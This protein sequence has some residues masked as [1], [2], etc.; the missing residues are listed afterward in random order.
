MT[1][2]TTSQP[3]AQAAPNERLREQIRLLGNLLGETIIA[4]E[5]RELFDIE[6]TMRALTK[7]HRAGNEDAGRQALEL[8]ERLAQNPRQAAAII[9]A[10]ATYFQLVNLAEEEQRVRVLRR[11][12]RAAARDGYP[13]RESIAAAIFRLREEGFTAEDVQAL[14]RDALVMPVFTAHPT[15]AQRRAMLTKLQALANILYEMDTRDLLPDEEAHLIQ[16]IREIIVALWQTNETRPRPPTV[17]DEV[18]NGLYYFE[19][20]LFDLIPRIYEDLQAA[21]ADMYPDAAFD[22][23]AFLRFGSWMGGDRDGNPYVTTDV[24]EETLRAQKALALKLYRREVAELYNELTMSQKRIGVSQALLDS[25][26]EDAARF[27]DEAPEILDRFADEPYRQK[28]V[29]MHRRIMAAQR[30]TEHAWTEGYHEPGAYHHP[31]EFLA[32]LRLIDES[33]R[34]HKGEILANGRLARLIR[35]VQVFGFHLATLDIRQ[36]SGRHEETLAEIFK[37][38]ALADDYA[39]LDENTKVALLEREINSPRPL[40]AQLTFSPDTNETVRVFRLIRRAHDLL[41]PRAIQSYIISMTTSVSD[42]LEVLL[43]AKDAN[44]FGQIDIVPLFETIEDLHNAP[45]IM[46]ALFEN[47]VYRQ[48]LAARGSRQQIMIGY[49][50]SNK[51][52]GYLTANWELFKAQRALAQT[53]DRYNIQLTLFHG[54][55]GTIGRGGGNAVRAILAQPPESVR[56]RFRVTEQG[57]VISHR[58]GNPHLAHRHLHQIMYAVLLSSGRRPH[59]ERENVWSNAL[60]EMAAI[61]F[62]TYRALVER[63]EF[64]RY[65]HE[66]TPIDHITRLNIG[67]RPAKRRQTQGISDLRAIPWVF[68][69][70][71][72]RVNLPGWY[73]LGTA[74]ETWV[75]QGDEEERIALLSEMYRQW[76]FFRTVID[77]AQMSL[78]KADMTIAAIYATLTDDATRTAV[79][80]PIREEHARTERMI[81]RITGYSDLLENEPWLQQSIRLRNPYVDPMNYIQVA[82]IRRLRETPPPENSAELEDIVLLAVNGIAAGLRNTG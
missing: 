8:A 11:R 58:Y 69:W 50:D 70:T 31:E 64:L 42:L 79:F 18:R 52:G 39:A 38:Y 29:F 67:S 49:S 44:L 48:H 65:F 9:K 63:P 13:V 60:D 27:P 82:L 56:G 43:L 77:N 15:E 41:G 30:E 1:L 22:I 40:T 54:R 26:P 80:D 28:L 4:Q 10:F 33:L 71:Q 37:R 32:D 3:T 45:R 16:R 55:G 76:P 35:Q 2:S 78:R 25:I 75:E 53:C 23:P 20:V 61:A 24:T 72:S 19:T 21:L 36:H 17:M 62:R 66:A 59:P 68:A 74:L 51:D 12:A 73:G 46:S 6:E 57:E 34:A 47:S 7:A 14:L 81:L 5:G